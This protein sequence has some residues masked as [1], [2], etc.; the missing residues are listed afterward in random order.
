MGHQ[1]RG[2]KMKKQPGY[3][4]HKWT[5]EELLEFIAM[6]TRGESV[7]AI[8][9]RFKI[10]DRSV[11]KKVSRLRGNGVMLPLRKGGHQPDRSNLSWTPEEVEYLIRRRVERATSDQ[12]ASELGRTYHAINALVVRLR[13]EGVEIPMYGC[14]VRKLWD[15]ETLKAAI[16]GRGLVPEEKRGRRAI[17]VVRN[18]VTK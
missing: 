3:T 13:K 8:G 15:A 10:A 2:D 9:E 5:T 16:V 7:R 11:N 6:W 14:G 1:E 4:G 18:G 17:A 12:I